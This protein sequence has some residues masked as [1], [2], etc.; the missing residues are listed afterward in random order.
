MKGLRGK[1]LLFICNRR[2]ARAMIRNYND[3]NC[4]ASVIKYC[5]EAQRTPTFVPRYE[6]QEPRF[7]QL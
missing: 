6:A 2:A 3:L 5:K 1:R 7:E 4:T